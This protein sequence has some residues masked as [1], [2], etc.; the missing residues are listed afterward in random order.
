[1]TAIKQEITP[2]RSRFDFINQSW[3]NAGA[4]IL[5]M[6]RDRKT[7]FGADGAALL[8]STN[9]DSAAT[10]NWAT[11]YTFPT[12][13]GSTV[14]GFVEL[15]NGEAMVV[16]TESGRANNLSRVYISSGWAANNASA[17]WTETLYTIGGKIVPHYC[18]YDWTNAK[19]GTVLISEEGPHTLGGVGNV[20]ADVRKSRRV[21]LSKDFGATWNLIFDLVDYAATQGV[22]Y[23]ASVHMHGCAYDQ[24]W[25]R[26]W[27]C[28]GDGTGDGK[29]IAG[30]G[31]T[32]VVYS[33]D[34]G[35]TWQKLPM[36]ALWTVTVS[37]VSESFQFISVAVFNNS[38][39][40][41]HDLT[42]PLAPVVYPKIGYRKM[43]SPFFGPA[44][45]S[46]VNGIPRKSVRDGH[47]P[48]F[49]TGG[50]IS[51]VQTGTIRWA[52][53]CTDDDGFT[54]SAV[55]GE[56]PLQSPAVTGQGFTQVLGPTI[57]GKV[58]VVG[59]SL[60]VNNDNTKRTMVADLVQT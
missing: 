6:S 57:N 15:E 40:F 17:T 46:A 12:T 42:Q 54:W 56:I 25:G 10:P 48:A 30:M 60:Y 43:G 23:P 39:V 28:Y 13:N 4:T 8:S 55:Y 16:T 1:M 44:Y 5:N 47:V 29:S 58:V 53:A 51:G 20:V 7:F 9:V 35:A 59:T 36:P 26:I 18:L 14:T 41:T 34:N 38:I 22:P 19:D 52:V 27:V 2:S 32:Q 24:D 49:F 37:T 50:T 45:S 21:W 3:I 11:L 31:N 33:D